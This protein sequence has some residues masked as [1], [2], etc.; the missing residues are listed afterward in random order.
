MPELGEK[1]ECPNCGTR[2]YDLGK[3]RPICPRCELDLTEAEAEAEAGAKKKK[4]KKA[5]K[6]KSDGGEEE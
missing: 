6:P 1:H 2:F 5:A 4:K 3:P